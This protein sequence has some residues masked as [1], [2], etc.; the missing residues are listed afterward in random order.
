[1]CLQLLQNMAFTIYFQS[2]KYQK[3]K[4]Y[5]F[6]L[7]LF[8]IILIYRQL[9]YHMMPRGLGMF[10][11]T[12]TF[13]VTAC[14]NSRQIIVAHRKRTERRGKVKNGNE[15]RGGGLLRDGAVDSNLLQDAIRPGTFFFSNEKE[16]KLFRK[17]WRRRRERWGGRWWLR[18]VKLF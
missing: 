14:T 17:R 18:R 12:Y 1:M 16:R 11:A 3:N 7:M 8:F 9:I 13:T 15:I 5:T 10:V 6:C 4:Y 2:S